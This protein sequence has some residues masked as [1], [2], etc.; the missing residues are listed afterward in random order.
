MECMAMA[1]SPM[2]EEAAAATLTTGTTATTPSINVSSRLTQLAQISSSR[3]RL[4]LNAITI[5]SF[6][7]ACHF[8][9]C[10]ILMFCRMSYSAEEISSTATRAISNTGP[11][12]MHTH[13]DMPMQNLR[14]RNEES[15]CKYMPRWRNW[16]RRYDFW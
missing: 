13:S 16:T 15:R 9:D 7:C 4:W 12:S 10:Q 3:P 1:A 8:A 6:I 11:W 2:T 14:R 5:F